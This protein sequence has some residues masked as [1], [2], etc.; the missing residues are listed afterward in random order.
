MVHKLTLSCFLIAFFLISFSQIAFGQLAPKEIS[1]K[2]F[3]IF[4]QEGP[5]QAV[6]YLFSTNKY[7]EES[8][9]D[10]NSIKD[11]LRDNGPAFGA[12]SNYELLSTKMA[13][14]DLE[15]LT[16]IVKY[17]RL[18]LVF[19]LLFYKPADEW[20]IQDLTFDTNLEVM[21]KDVN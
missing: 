9:K 8:K 2:F 1:T 14:K 6:D 21:L 15:L 10:I 12:Y 4:K 18:P 13:G 17:D 19:K 11:K 7:S 5:S 16:F 20:R 3:D